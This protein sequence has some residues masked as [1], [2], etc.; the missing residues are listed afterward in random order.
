VPEHLRPGQFGVLLLG[1]VA[2]G[3]I[4]ATLADLCVRGFLTVEQVERAGDGGDWSL[5]SSRR[6]AGRGGAPLLGYEEKL[7]DGLSRQADACLLSSLAGQ[8]THL[9]DATRSAVVH[10]SVHR[11]WL[12]HLDHQRTDEGDELA[13]RLRSFQRQL[14]H[15]VS[16]PGAQGVPDELMPYA[17]R[18][19][20][21]AVGSAPLVDFAHAWVEAFGGLPGWRPPEYHRPEPDSGPLLNNDDEMSA[22]ILTAAFFL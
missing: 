16:G 10:D 4:A 13:G 7:L 3:D 6:P 15:F 8:A 12:R 1:R 11:G 19:G 20:L 9:L 22:Q 17:L 21:L 2:L 18:F 14:R 5:L